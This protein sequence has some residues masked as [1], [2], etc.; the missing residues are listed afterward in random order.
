MNITTVPSSSYSAYYWSELKDLSDNIKLE[1]IALLSGSLVKNSKEE[2]KADHWAD[3]FCG[4]WADNRSAEE[5]VDDI[6]SMRT[7]NT[8]LEE[9]EL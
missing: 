9:I 1:L 6:R 7:K 4:V 2:D 8:R 3:Q 5:I